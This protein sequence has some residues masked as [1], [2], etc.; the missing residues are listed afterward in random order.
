MRP[1]D[2]GTTTLYR[3]GTINALSL[4]E[5][6]GIPSLYRWGR[7]IWTGRP[8]PE[9]EK[10]YF[11]PFYKQLH[12][13]GA[14]GPPKLEVQLPQAPPIPADYMFDKK[15]EPPVIINI[16]KDVSNILAPPDDVKKNFQAMGVPASPEDLAAQVAGRSMVLSLTSVPGF[17]GMTKEAAKQLATIAAVSF[18]VP[19]TM[20][21][22]TRTVQGYPNEALP[23]F[24]EV[25][26][27]ST[28]VGDVINAFRS[29]AKLPPSRIGDVIKAARGRQPGATG[30]VKDVF[31][32]EVEDAL[33]RLK[34]GDTS[35]YDQLLRQ[36]EDW[37]KKIEE[38]NKL[39]ETR[40]RGPLSPEDETR[41]TKLLKE[42]SEIRDKYDLLK[43][44]IDAAR[45]L[46]LEAGARR[47][48]LEA[49]TISDLAN[50]AQAAPPGPPQKD[51]MQWLLRLDYDLLQKLVKN[52]Q[53]LAKYARRFGVDE[54]TLAE[55]A[56]LLLRE[57]QWENLANLPDS[58]LKKILMD[59]ALLKKYASEFNI[60][61]DALRTRLEELLQ[62]HMGVK[63]PESPPEKPPIEPI[64]RPERPPTHEK[65]P[66]FKPPETEGTVT[67]REGQVLI[68]RPEEGPRLNV[69]RLEDLPSV[70]ARLRYLLRHRIIDE[71][72]SSGRQR[73]SEVAGEKA[74]SAEPS[75]TKDVVRSQQEPVAETP[76]A[77]RTTT[78]DRTAVTTSTDEQRTSRVVTERELVRFVP[79]LPPTLLAMPVS[80]ALPA[81]AQIISQIVGAPVSLRL[82]PP[83]NGSMQLGAYLRS[84]LP[85]GG[86]GGAQREV[87]V[88]L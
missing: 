44:Y 88:L 75:R 80:V 35:K 21:A 81:V 76:S 3:E 58:E 51:L 61:E 83:P 5:L 27:A 8:Y 50:A 79:Y 9:V 20:A 69:K 17:A 26:L 52:P 59:E 47:A 18:G 71:E 39:Y 23:A 85:R 31:M 65:S 42:V 25:G 22:A 66:E 7:A 14:A 6:T 11:E 70:E 12:D 62:Q 68:V 63:P 36:F 82:P 74:G 57:R 60:S 37:Q 16:P 4:L 49:R 46:G 29:L 15:R 33:L 41:Y 2:W 84:I 53:R 78:V 28:V 72:V 10:E 1:L 73:L 32:D 64:R 19:G 87:Y 48:E 38:F 56:A 45:E 13:V 54:Q 40:Q 24:I 86:L 77:D 30:G 43:Q 55:R 67:T 34:K